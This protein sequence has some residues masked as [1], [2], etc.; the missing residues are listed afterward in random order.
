MSIPPARRPRDTGL[1]REEALALFHLWHG[2]PEA[3]PTVVPSL[4]PHSATV[5]SD[6]DR[7]GIHPLPPTV[8]IPRSRAPGAVWLISA[9]PEIGPRFIPRASPIPESAAARVAVA[10]LFGGSARRAP[11]S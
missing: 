3:P 8:V 7:A 2:L 1:T 6:P 10:R 11:Y 5:E 9:L 4:R